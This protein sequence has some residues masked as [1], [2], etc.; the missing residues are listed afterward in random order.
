M[1]EIVNC[2]FENNPN[3]ILLLP[4]GVILNKNEL[5][6]QRETAKNQGEKNECKKWIQL[7]VLT[8]NR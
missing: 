1:D 2:S 8:D 6:Q 3:K 4:K 5:K 7:T